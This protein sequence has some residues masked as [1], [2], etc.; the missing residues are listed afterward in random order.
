MQLEAY[1]QRDDRIV[2]PLGSTEQHAYL[3]LGTDGYGRS[4]T[5]EDLRALFEID[6]PHIAAATLV[7]LAR[8]G[9]MAP[10]KA[11]KGVRELGLDPDKIDPLAV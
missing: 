7:A 3:S 4:G 2:L 1:L 11:A 9:A 5:R 8:C 6:P 10:A